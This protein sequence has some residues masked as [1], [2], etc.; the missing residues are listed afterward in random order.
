MKKWLLL[1]SA[2]ISITSTVTNAATNAV[3]RPGTVSIFLGDGYDYFASK[4]NLDNVNI[5]FV[6]LGYN[7][8]E[9]YAIEGFLGRFDTKFKPSQNDNRQV[10]GTMFAIDGLYRFN[11]YKFL[12]PYVLA[13]VGITGINPNRTSANNAANINAAVGTQIQLNKVMAIRVDARDFYTMI[14]GKND[15]V[16]DAGLGVLLDLCW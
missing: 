13:G 14:G 10:N 4:R 6:T 3:N 16:L 9:R 2:C 7:F 8:T 12:A 15:I 11:P 5:P 1:L